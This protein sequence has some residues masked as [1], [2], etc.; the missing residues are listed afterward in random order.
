MK[1]DILHPECLRKFNASIANLIFA[2]Q[3]GQTLPEE[4]NTEKV[5]LK[6]GRALRFFSCDL[7]N[8]EIK[9][10]ERCVAR[11]IIAKGQSYY[12]WE[13]EYIKERDGDE[14]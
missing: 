8:V 10:G 5:I 9:L 13:D 12:S 6:V 1:R 7:C 4:I 2:L 11:S 14:E 3:T